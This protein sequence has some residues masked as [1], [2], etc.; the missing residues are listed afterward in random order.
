[1]TILAETIRRVRFG[2]LKRVLLNRCG[3]VLPDDDAG[4]D[5]LEELLC[6]ATDKKLANVVSVWAPWMSAAEAQRLIAYVKSMRQTCERLRRR[7][8]ASA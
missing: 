5:Y 7:L 8:W 6:L 1:M 2:D 4:R 3:T